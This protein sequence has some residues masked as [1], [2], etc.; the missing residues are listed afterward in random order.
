L[1]SDSTPD[2]YRAVSRRLASPP[3][4]RRLA[5]TKKKEYDVTRS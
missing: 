3:A 1:L 5:A 2:I 4:R